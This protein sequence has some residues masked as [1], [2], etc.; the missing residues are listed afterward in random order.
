MLEGVVNRIIGVRKEELR[1][2]AEVYQDA[3]LQQALY[4]DSHLGRI[5]LD[6]AQRELY[7]QR[8]NQYNLWAVIWN[9]ERVT[10]IFSRE[11]YPIEKLTKGHIRVVRL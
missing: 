2:I 7:N 8:A 1:K 10:R 9:Q 6:K 11:K 3:E 5:R 4:S